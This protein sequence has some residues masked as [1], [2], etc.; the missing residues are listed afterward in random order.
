[1]KNFFDLEAGKLR[2]IENR[3]FDPKGPNFSAGYYEKFINETEEHHLLRD[4][5]SEHFTYFGPL[6]PDTRQCIDQL[7]EYHLSEQYHV[8]DMKDDCIIY[9]GNLPN[10]S[11]VMD[12][13][14][15]SYRIWNMT[16]INNWRKTKV[17]PWAH[18]LDT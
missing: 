18:I 3:H 7:D 2:P 11:E 1:M 16:N 14:A 15:G 9:T 10:C 6:H 17:G 4:L 13:L 12:T 5:V 8:Y